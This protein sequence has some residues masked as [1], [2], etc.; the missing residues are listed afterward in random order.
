MAFAIASSTIMAAAKKAPGKKIVR[1]SR[2]QRSG[3]V[4]PNRSLWNGFAA[5]P[6]APPYLD[7]TLPGDAGF[8]P[9]GLSAPTQYLQFDIDQLDQSAAVNKSGNVIG[10][11][12]KVDNKPTE[13]TIVV[14]CCFFTLLSRGPRTTFILLKVLSDMAL[15]KNRPKTHV[16]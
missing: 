15:T 8:D 3:N 6:E 4:G 13:R 10:T 2:V 7:G 16:F 1:P 9:L 12:K 11:L 5:D 14:S